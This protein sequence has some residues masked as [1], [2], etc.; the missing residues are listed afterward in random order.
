MRSIIVSYGSSFFSPQ[1][2]F[3]SLRGPR[4]RRTS[5]AKVLRPIQIR[6]ATSSLEKISPT[7]QHNSLQVQPPIRVPVT[8]SA[9]HPR[10]RR[11][12]FR[13][14]DLRQQSRLFARRN[15]EV[16]RNRAG[17]RLLFLA[18]FLES[19]VGAQRVPERIEPKKGRRN[20]RRAVNPAIIGRL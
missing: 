7:C 8:Q 18:E 4:R 13:R 12:A 9:F 14:R 19:G 17:S 15:Q 6:L 1:S 20:S 2:Y 11:T 3:L 10:A 5:G 16:N